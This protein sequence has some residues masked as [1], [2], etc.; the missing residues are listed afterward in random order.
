MAVEMRLRPSSRRKPA[1]RRPQKS[2]RDA[3]APSGP[4]AR[5]NVRPTNRTLRA[6][7]ELALDRPITRRPIEP[8]AHRCLGRLP[9]GHQQTALQR[10][11]GDLNGGHR[12]LSVSQD[13]L[14]GCQECHEQRSVYV[15][16]ERLTAQIRSVRRSP[17]SG[18]Y[19]AWP[20]P[21]GVACP[22]HEAALRACVATQ[23]AV[24]RWWDAVPS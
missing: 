7:S 14:G 13:F 11:L 5:L 18:G 24:G 4:R 16:P 2:R 19:H 20:L 10:D 3:L 17:M 21:D 8:R 23:A 9:V 12:P 15:T 1:C 6:L 22:E